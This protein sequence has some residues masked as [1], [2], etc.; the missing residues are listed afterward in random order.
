MKNQFSI[1]DLTPIEYHDGVYFKRDDLYTPFSDL[2]ELSGGKTRQMQM[3][4]DYLFKNNLWKYNGL[5]TYSGVTSAQSLIVSRIA[6]ENNIPCIIGVGVNKKHFDIEKHPALSASKKY[7]AEVVAVAGIGFSKVLETRCKYIADKLN[8]FLI[9]FGLNVDKHAFGI[10]RGI[11]SQVQNLPNDIDNLIIPCGSGVS[12]A[13]II[14]G[15]KLYNKKVKRIVG[16]QISG[17]DRKQKINTILSQFDIKPDYEFYIDETYNYNKHVKYSINDNFDLSMVYEAKAYQYF[18]NRKQELNISD[19]EKTL[20]WCIGC[21]NFLYK[22]EN[23]INVKRD[24]SIKIAVNDFK[25][26]VNPCTSEMINSQ[27]LGK[28]CRNSYSNLGQPLIIVMDNEQ[29]NL[30]ELS[31]DYNFSIDQTNHL[32]RPENHICPFQ[33]SET[34][35]CKLHNSDKKPFGCLIMPLQ[36]N[37]NEIQIQKTFPKM[38]CQKKDYPNVAKVPFYI[39]FRQSMVAVFGEVETNRIIKE[40]ES[41]K[42]EITVNISATNIQ[43]MNDIKNIMKKVNSISKSNSDQNV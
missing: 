34:N 21:N 8:Y 17:Y 12:M 15:L 28:C 23:K 41:G 4:M 10:I 38:I 35:F 9:D 13:G 32:L 14:V 39:G 27:C 1:T 33:D 26:L 16:I 36:I 5:I 3:L 42:E 43:K 22:D 18:Q 2:P 19:N 25:M 20:F 7:N 6:Y 31:N 37:G 29:E 40:I 30:N 11:A 24:D